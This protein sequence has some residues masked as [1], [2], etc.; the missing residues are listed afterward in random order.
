[1]NA[2]WALGATVSKQPNVL[3]LGSTGEDRGKYWI[4]QI[5][6]LIPDAI[7]EANIETCQGLALT[8]LF[9]VGLDDC[10]FS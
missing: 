6:Y 8:A 7:E 3:A 9:F 4:S 10:T 5:R 1:M 2:I